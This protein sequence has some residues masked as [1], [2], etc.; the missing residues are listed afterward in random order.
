MR[1]RGAL[2]VVDEGAR[3][4]EQGITERDA[5]LMRE[6]R[7]DLAV[8]AQVD[9]RQDQLDRA[10]PL[11]FA[12][13]DRAGAQV[14]ADLADRILEPVGGALAAGVPRGGDFGDEARQRRRLARLERHGLVGQ[15]ED[16]RRGAQPRLD[17]RDQLVEQ[18]QGEGIVPGRPDHIGGTVDRDPPRQA[19]AVG[20]AAVEDD[21]GQPAVEMDAPAL[22]DR[23]AKL[24]MLA[25]LELCVIRAAR[26]P[27]RHSS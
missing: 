22:A 9:R 6:L 5:K 11:A 21:V 19:G 2:A 13:L 3:R 27:L 8:G 14:G 10:L 4:L 23:L 12:P 18:G 24:A 17:R 25:E 15:R 26:A 7:I 20:L 16:E 1:R